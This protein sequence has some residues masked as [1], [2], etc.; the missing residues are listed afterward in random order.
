MFSG[1]VEK[2]YPVVFKSKSQVGL[3]FP[4]K[5]H[6]LG[7]SIA[8]NG[9]CLTISKKLRKAKDNIFIFD[10]SK[11]TRLKTS[12][13]RW[14]IGDRVNIEKALRL[15]DVIGGHL[16]QGHVDGIGKIH[17]II[18]Q[19]E[20]VDIW[21]Q[22]PK[23]IINYLVPKGSIT[24]DGISLTVVDIKGNTFSSAIIP[25]TLKITNLSKLSVGDSV[26]LEVD[27]VA[28]YVKKF[29]TAK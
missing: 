18:D 10:V 23:Y 11:E 20:G 4:S 25:H 5:K 28:K 16:V 1:I 7:D 8:I 3:K 6:K 17:S 19:K 29:I 9:I 12:V 2:T 15:N 24:I 13:D 21:F 14:K 27:V 22:A 26:N